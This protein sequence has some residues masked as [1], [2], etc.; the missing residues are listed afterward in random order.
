MQ[1]RRKFLS[2]LGGA[3]AAVTA[4]TGL[5]RAVARPVPLSPLM[6]VPPLDGWPETYSLCVKLP[7]P[8]DRPTDNPYGISYWIDRPTVTVE[9]HH[10]GHGFYVGQHTGMK[11]R[12]IAQ[13]R[14]DRLMCINTAWDGEWRRDGSRYDVDPKKI[15]E[16]IKEIRRTMTF[17]P[18]IQPW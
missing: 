18:P 6:T 5:R 3:V 14:G 10:V 8:I 1:T 15:E 16:R 13:K 7:Q 4:W 17:H 12:A 2:V 11:L 9:C